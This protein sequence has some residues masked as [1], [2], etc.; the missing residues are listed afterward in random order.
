[1]TDTE[2]LEKLTAFAIAME[3]WEGDM[4]LDNEAWRGGMA[5]LP[6]LTYPLWDRLLELQHMRNQ[7][8]E[9]IER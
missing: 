4:I 2:R 8:L 9:G 5:P 3:Q 1:M 6:T 7:S